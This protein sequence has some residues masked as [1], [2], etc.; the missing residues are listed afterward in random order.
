MQNCFCRWGVLN[1]CVARC[2][3]IWNERFHWKLSIVVVGIPNYHYMEKQLW[4]EID[5]EQTCWLALNIRVI[6][7]ITKVVKSGPNFF[8]FFLMLSNADC[9]L[10]HQNESS[11]VTRTAKY[12]QMFYKCLV[13]CSLNAWGPAQCLEDNPYFCI[14]ITR[15]Q[16]AIRKLFLLCFVLFF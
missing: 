10:V 5:Q 16:A 14:S 1:P 4:W 12:F 2:K 13:H 3:S 15:T 8:S 11:K 9:L 6:C 7:H